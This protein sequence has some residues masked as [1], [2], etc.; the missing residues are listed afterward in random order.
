MRSILHVAFILVFSVRVALSK[1]V[2][3]CGR[4]RHSTL[5]PF[6]QG[7]S[8]K[9]ELFY[10][11]CDNP[12]CYM[13]MFALLPD[14]LQNDIYDQW[15]LNS[16]DLGS[17][18]S[19]GE[20]FQN[21]EFIRTS[22][23]WYYWAASNNFE[24]CW[25]T[26]IL[27]HLGNHGSVLGA[28]NNV[29]ILPETNPATSN[30]K[31]PRHLRTLQVGWLRT[32]RA[33]CFNNNSQQYKWLKEQ[34]DRTVNPPGSEKYFSYQEIKTDFGTWAGT[35]GPV[36]KGMLRSTYQCPDNM[37]CHRGAAEKG[38]PFL[39]RSYTKFLDQIRRIVREDAEICFALENQLPNKNAYWFIPGSLPDSRN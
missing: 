1:G 6:F 8:Y 2:I 29:L 34:I 25:F 33:I 19:V 9:S 16:Y 13:A 35:I 26:D 32:D 4:M 7:Q 15:F 18:L 11:H 36:M 3:K 22:L 24:I 39:P 20:S 27:D 31:M 5:T 30:Y 12:L 38:M 14:E 17:M 23:D 28:V 10:T 21:A 37:Y